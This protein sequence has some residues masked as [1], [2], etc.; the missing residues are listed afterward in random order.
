YLRLLG[1]PDDDV[2]FLRVINT[3]KREIGPAT[4]EILGTYAQRRHISLFSACFELG[5]EQELPQR[6]V[7]RLRHFCEWLVDVAD[8][9]KR[10]DTLG[11]IRE[12]VDTLDYREWLKDNAATP[13][14]AERKWENVEELMEWLG[15]LLE[16]A[17]GG[18]DPLG[19]AVSK[20]MLLDVLDRTKEDE[21]GDRV[22]LMTLHA[23]KGL[24]FPHVYLV[25][26]EE[27]ILPH[28]N[29]IDQDSIEEERRLAYVGITRAQKSLT[30]SYCRQRKR[31]GET[32][33]CEPSRFLGELPEDDL[34]WPD[35]AG[36]D[37]EEKKARGKAA[38][39]QMKAL[40]QET[41]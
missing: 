33:S 24:E 1:N 18:E 34:E 39:S 8:R 28:Q 6:G 10:G 3:P 11:V 27:G 7:Q 15:R 37:P 35:K 40:L 14:Q 38:L 19:S 23:A 9:A 31:Y 36:L 5:L 21:T 22:A 41:G 16:E 17:E 2:A 12:L 32:V 25:G 4:L 29:S 30:M 13:R 26:M 20:L